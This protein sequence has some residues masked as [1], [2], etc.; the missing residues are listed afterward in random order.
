MID[1]D[2][3]KSECCEEQ[4]VDDGLGSLICANCGATVNYAGMV[5]Q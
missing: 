3:H 4:I 5:I 1:P 2:E